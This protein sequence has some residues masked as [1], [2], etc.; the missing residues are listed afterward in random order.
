MFMHPVHGG[1]IQLRRWEVRKCLRTYHIHSLL[2]HWSNPVNRS[3]PSCMPPVVPE[4]D[5]AID[6]EID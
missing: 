2:A 6:V 1:R 5:G 3:R 4:K